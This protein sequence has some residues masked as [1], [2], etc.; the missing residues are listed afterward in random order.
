MKEKSNIKLP[1]L[2]KSSSVDLLCKFIAALAVLMVV[3]EVAA[4]FTG[5][6]VYIL[7]LPVIFG[8]FSGFAIQGL[9]LKLLKHK[10]SVDYSWE[11]NVKYFHL[12]YA[13]PT[14]SFEMLLAV[15]LNSGIHKLL[16]KMSLNGQ[17]VYYDEQSLAP[18][19]CTLTFI[20]AAFAGI[21]IQFFPYYRIISMDRMLYYL[22]ISGLS[23]V[24]MIMFGNNPSNI[25]PFFIIFAI[26]SIIILNQ[27]YIIRT[28]GNAAIVKLTPS[29]RLSNMRMVLLCLVLAAF[30]GIFA[31]IVINGLYMLLRLIFYS[32][33]L[34]IVGYKQPNRPN[35]VDQVSQEVTNGVFGG[36]M[37]NMFSFGAFIFILLS[38][39]MLV[40]FARSGAV[41]SFLKSLKQ[42]LDDFIAMFMSVE[43]YTPEAREIEI[44]YRD[45]VENVTKPNK[46]RSYAHVKHTVTLREFNSE[47]ASMKTYEEKLSYSYIVM[48]NILSQINTAIKTTDTPRER[49]DKIKA[50]I[51]S[52]SIDEITDIIEQI[53]YAEK[54]AD[55]VLAEATLTKIRSIVERKL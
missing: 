22:A 37:T 5:W 31:F 50:Y 30:F 2:S 46:N 24:L 7:M 27:S 44:N 42:L 14:A 53:K 1:L 19:L 51:F 45:S 34:W 29:G 49:A 13:I 40:V 36:K 17:I 35:H 33:L 38:V 16:Q 25:A 12:P 18:I 15:L 52:D 55:P 47:L 8:F 48:V 43:K 21:Y 54:S 3:L 11:G 26:C 10:K 41:K 4:L 20:I 6:M 39:I 28:Y 32:V 9:L 23:A